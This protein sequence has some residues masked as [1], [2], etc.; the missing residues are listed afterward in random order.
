VEERDEEDAVGAWG[1]GLGSYLFRFFVAECAGGRGLALTSGPSP[2]S[3][4]RELN[5]QRQG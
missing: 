4:R 1:E 5:V 3:G 2:N